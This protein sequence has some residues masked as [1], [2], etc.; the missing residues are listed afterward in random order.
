MKAKTL[1]LDIHYVTT[2]SLLHM[3]QNVSAYLL[4]VYQSDLFS[5]F[6]INNTNKINRW[7]Y[8]SQKQLVCC[9][10]I[11][12]FNWG[13]KKSSVLTPLRKCVFSR[14]N[15]LGVNLFYSHRCSHVLDYIHIIL[16]NQ[17]SK[18]SQEN[19]YLSIIISLFIWQHINKF[20]VEVFVCRAWF[21]H[22]SAASNF[23]PEV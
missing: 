2:W 16:F 5:K 18:C 13:K 21:M 23:I 9:N 14:H 8:V 7:W 4:D 11:A 10:N 17:W 1:A 12:A 19:I 15:L 20:A 3:N 6:T 22:A